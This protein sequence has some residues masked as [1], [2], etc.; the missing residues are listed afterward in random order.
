M[1]V[2]LTCILYDYM[3]RNALQ[4]DIE[5]WRSAHI[6]LLLA[7]ALPYWTYVYFLSNIPSSSPHPKLSPLTSPPSSHGRHHLHQL[8]LCRISHGSQ[9]G[10]VI[11]R[12]VFHMMFV[13]TY[14]IFTVCAFSRRNLE[15]CTHFKQGDVL[16]RYLWY[17]LLTRWLNQSRV[18]IYEQLEQRRICGKFCN[19]FISLSTS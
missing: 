3:T 14:F 12:C 18:S 8:R 2:S 4:H 1:T 9:W 17:E 11:R 15:D 5:I 6:H 7:C 10:L 16:L 19:I 13:V